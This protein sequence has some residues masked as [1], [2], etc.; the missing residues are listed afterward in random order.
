MIS[1]SRGAF[2]PEVCMNLFPQNRGSRE[3]RV[4]AAPAVSCAMCTRKCAHEHTGTAGALR[5][6]LRNGLTT[7]AVL[8]LET[9]SFCLH[10]CRLDGGSPPV[11]NDVATGSLAPAT[12]VGTTRFCRTLQ[13][14]SSC[15]R[16]SLT[17]TALRTHIAPDAVASTA[18]RPAFVTTRDP[19]LLSERDGV[20]MTIDLDRRKALYFSAAD[21]TTQITL[22]C[23]IKSQFSRNGFSG[24]PYA[25]AKQDAA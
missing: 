22:K 12:G 17:E 4:L 7:N 25:G 13:R 3:C 18:S 14:R 19:P 5:H 16:C 8:S 1:P 24:R 10:R 21:W 20:E 15:T 23:L 9:N 11:G 2:A 6:P